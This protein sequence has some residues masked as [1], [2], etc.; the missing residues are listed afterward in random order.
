MLAC[1]VCKLG[2]VKGETVL[3]FRVSGLGL[4]FELRSASASSGAASVAG[5]RWSAR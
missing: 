4:E 5:G 2:V 3:R 1:A